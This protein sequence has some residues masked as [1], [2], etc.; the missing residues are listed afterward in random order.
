MAGLDSVKAVAICIHELTA[1]ST[2]LTIDFQWEVKKMETTNVSQTFSTTI[3]YTFTHTTKRKNVCQNKILFT[4]QIYPDI[5][6]V[7]TSIYLPIS[8]SPPVFLFLPSILLTLSLD[9][10]NNA[11]KDGNPQFKNIG[12]NLLVGVT[13]I[14]LIYFLSSLPP[15]FPL[16]KYH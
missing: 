12:I 14:S 15:S 5:L 10:R 7:S 8:P 11:R 2:E 9:S 6:Y 1:L 4:A 3:Q 16:K 13:I